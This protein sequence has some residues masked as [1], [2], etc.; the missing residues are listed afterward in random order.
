MN[1]IS[2]LHKENY[3]RIKVEKY[4]ADRRF[5]SS[6]N[7]YEDF[8]STNY[9]G[10]DYHPQII[11][12]PQQYLK[13]WGSLT[14]WS[15]MEADCEIFTLLENRISQFLGCHK[16]LLSPTISSGCTSH[17]PNLFK[18]GAYF[19]SDRFLH[20][21]VKTGTQLAKAYGAK[22]KKFDITDL[23]DLEDS[24]KQAGNNDK[25]IFVDGVHSLGRY[26]APVNDLQYLCDKY[27]AWLFIDDAH[28]FGILG[29]IPS[30]NSLWGMNGN[31]IINYL[32][33][34]W[35][36]TFYT[37]SFGKAFCTHTAFTS[38]PE[39]YP[40][41]LAAK[42]DQFLYSAPISPALVAMAHAALDINENIGVS[43]R[44]KLLN[45]VRYFIAGLN[46]LDIDYTNVAS[47][48]VIYIVSGSVERTKIW[49]QYL[50]KR[51]IFSGLRVFPL[52]PRNQCGF[53][54]SITATNSKT[55]IDNVL[56]V[57]SE[58]KRLGT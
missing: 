58:C 10:I 9:L 16:V 19:F 30:Q 40:N 36:R 4:L 2:T 56:N 11:E 23:S 21:V 44:A 49:H 42:S 31:G 33:A 25:C 14:Q 45:L 55:Q 22:L 41:D 53:R 5:L 50:L 38:I 46:D 28:G 26:L 13:E 6:G 1:E 43:L 8:S 32:N 57:L 20:P 47:H 29:E 3:Y 12:S 18:R 27:N 52:T 48:P 24:L 34:S 39:E 37:S 54:F 51:G 35:S 7:I 17:I 15:R